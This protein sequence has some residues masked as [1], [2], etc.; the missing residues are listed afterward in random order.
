MNENQ[1]TSPIDYTIIFVVIA[2]GITSCFTLYTLDPL[3]GSAD[4]GSYLKQMVWYLLGGIGAAVV[5]IMDYDRLHQLVWFLYGF[6]IL[7]LLMLFF[8]FPPR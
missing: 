3:L 8:N 5:M 2:L 6:G 1:H 7:M 4:Q